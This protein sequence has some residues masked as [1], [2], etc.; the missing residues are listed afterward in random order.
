[1]FSENCAFVEKYVCVCAILFE[2]ERAVGYS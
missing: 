2:F 1:M